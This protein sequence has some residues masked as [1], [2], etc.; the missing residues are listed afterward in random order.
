MSVLVKDV[1]MPTSCPCV[2]G[3]GYNLYCFAVNGIPAR[4]EEFDECRE[5]QTRPSWCPL[6]EVEEET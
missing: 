6:V 4:I 2:I 5:N 1:K 3:V